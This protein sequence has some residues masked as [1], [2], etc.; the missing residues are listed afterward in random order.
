[1]TDGPVDLEEFGKRRK[2]RGKSNGQTPP[3]PPREDG[4]RL[5][6]I[7][8][9]DRVNEVARTCAKEIDNVVFLR[10]PVPTAL[11]YADESVGQASAKSDGP[12]DSVVVDGVLH[13]RGSPILVNP[14]PALIQY[15]LD[16]RIVFKKYN[17]RAK[18]FIPKSCPLYIA[19]RVLGAAPELK[20]RP[21]AGIA[22]VPLLYNGE[23]IV[24][25]G[26]HDQTRLFL[27]YSGRL[28]PIP[29]RPTKEQAL[30]ALDVMLAPFVGYFNHL[31]GEALQ[32][33]RT[34]FV[35]AVMTAGQR[36]S[37]SK[38]PAILFDGTTP[39][40]GKGKSARA[41]AAIA[42]GGPPALIVEGFSEEEFEKRIDAAILS[43]ANVI[44]CDNLQ[45]QIASSTLESGLTE[46]FAMIRQFGSQST[47]TVLVKALILFTGNNV[48]MRADMLRRTLVVRIIARSETPETLVFPFDP[49]EMAAA[50]RDKILGAIF[51]VARAWQQVRDTDEGRTIRA[52]TLGSFEQWSEMVAAPVAWLLGVNPIDLI[53]Q[54]KA[55]DPRIGEERALFAELAAWQDSLLGDDGRPRST[56]LARE[57]AKGLSAETWSSVLRFTGETPTPRQVGEFLKPYRDKYFSGRQL[58][59]RPGRTGI[60][61]WQLQGQHAHACS[62]SPHAG[63]SQEEDA[64]YLYGGKDS[65]REPP[66][67]ADETLI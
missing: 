8:A 46:G 41:L 59:G 48:K 34:A 14:T 31:D 60:M 20:F 57:A 15:F 17:E 25:R 35:A 58:I 19:Q 67:P 4:D 32:E 2:K 13:P 43:A 39:G 30:A 28:P 6:V 40:C 62:S 27:A 33:L 37:M 36:A 63:I 3:E 55:Q 1:M 24:K 65:M 45:R 52:T 64:K 51:T 38:A 26:Y 47:V 66:D 7:L 61:V 18:E 10:G 49:A 50:N 11:V 5:G 9:E 42:S 53:Q 22:T 29:K 56:W 44:L 16:E 12:A 21:I 54:R 23:L